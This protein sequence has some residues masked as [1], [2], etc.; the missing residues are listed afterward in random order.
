MHGFPLKIFN[1]E[2]LIFPLLTLFEFEKI[3]KIKSFIVGTTNQII[4]NHNKIKYDLIINLD[5]NKINFNNEIPEKIYKNTKDEKNLITEILGKLKD[6]YNDK[7]EN[8]MVNMQKIESNF[9]GSDDYIRNLFKNYFFEMMINFSLTKQIIKNFKID[10]NNKDN[11][12]DS[13]E[14]LIQLHL[15]HIDS[16]SQKEIEI[17]ELK[18]EIISID[19]VNANNG[20][21]FSVTFSGNNINLNNN[22][23]D[24]ESYDCEDKRNNKGK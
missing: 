12:L 15:P 14:P 1:K 21:N 23:S 16:H 4:M 20:N 3:E 8:W 19:N 5:T 17:K 24:D 6:N 7:E 11:M 2:S 9:I 18:S 13:K 10:K 22:G